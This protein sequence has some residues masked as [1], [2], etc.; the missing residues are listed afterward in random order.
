[1]SDASLP[2]SS[3]LE[4]LDEIYRRYLSDPNSVD[5]SWQRL[6]SAPPSTLFAAPTATEGHV[7]D[8]AK[9]PAVTTLTRSY[10][11]RGHLEAN[12]DPLGGLRRDAQPDLDPGTYGLTS[13]D[14]D[15][16]VP[17]GAMADSPAMTLRELIARLR[18]TYCGNIGVEFMHIPSPERR[19]W[20]E[21]RMERVLNRPVVDPAT[22]THV[23]DG[24]I[25]AA[26]IERFLHQKYVGTK[27]FSIEGGET[28]IPLLELVL[29]RAGDQGVEETVIGM[30]HR[31]RLNV[32]TNILK[33]SPAT[34]FAEF[35]DIDLQHTFGSGD[36][37]Y[38]LGFESTHI[39]RKGHTLALSLAFN[40]SHLE[41]V[42]PVV[43]GRVRAKQRRYRDEQHY[44]VLGVLVHGDAAFAGQGLVSETLNLSD[45]H[46]YRTGGTVHVIV[47]NQ[48]GFT[49]SPT[50]SRSTP[51]PTDVAKMIQIPIFHVNGDDPDAVAHVVALAM[52]YRKRF[53]TD[54]VIDM[55]CFRRYGHNEGDEPSFT[56]PLLYQQ[57]K[58]HPA[59]YELY[60]E[61]LV[62]A[63]VVTKQ[64][65]ADRVAHIH[66]TL[67]SAMVRARSGDQNTARPM[68]TEIR[69][70]YSGGLDGGSPEV[71]TGVAHDR[72]VEI[73]TRLAAIPEGFHAH[74]KIVRLMDQR[75]QM[76]RGERKLDWAMGEAL[77]FGTLVGDGVDV[78][79]SGQDSRRG[80]FSQRHAVIVDIQ[81]GREHKAADA[82]SATLG[83]GHAQLRIFDSSLS[84][85][86][87]L[88][89][90]YG[91]S[92][93]YPDGLVIWEAQFGD[94]VNGAQVI[95]DQ[96]VSSCEDKWSVL[97]GLVMMLPHG[98][99]GQGPEHSSARFER[100]LQLAAKDN[101]QICY[102]TTPAQIFHLLRR[103]VLRPYRKPLVILTPKS[104]LR[105]PEAT[106][107][108]DELTSGSFLRVIDDPEPP[109]V[110]S[111]YRVVLC[112]GKIYYDLVEERRRRGDLNSAIVRIEQ[113]YPFRDHQL[114]A[115]VDR[116]V[117]ATELVWVQEEPANMGA[118][119]FIKPRLRR[120][121]GLRGVRAVTRPESASPATGSMKKHVMEQRT[122]LT[123]AF[124]G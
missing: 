95:L 64:E 97:S 39:T 92:L 40:P 99:E 44:K 83:D 84:E 117:R 37:K 110:M 29:E 45:L 43:V 74:P 19:R 48:I 90:E 77:A 24:L 54:V 5:A 12:L 124:G 113:L 60:G 104:L 46:G 70:R 58:S 1:M 14:L 65:I 112:T 85:V 21:E 66:T 36:V 67:D 120:I 123:E 82:I 100:F 94:F 106:S 20:L 8:V 6:F 68:G 15:K 102:P 18:A 107:T 27:R 69:G 80:T 71:E 57:I 88:G 101:M 76:A 111:V 4:F 87:V 41:A 38:H 61:R 81:S 96:F 47:N 118:H 59:V 50:D 116:Y 2:L 108:L 9:M 86:G 7:I 13:G 3:D 93:E 17:A 105:L 34:L 115:V 89:F 79:M 22:Q 10:R 121:A 49:T 72:L 63:G 75:A 62:R 53:E 42:D 122:L 78:R 25:A 28:L 119:R 31:G 55:F 32:L 52:D 23:L 73:G 33:K 35:E 30:A 91:Y 51:Y 56:Q 26:E 109:P 114:A 98:Y 11:V 103:Q 16:V